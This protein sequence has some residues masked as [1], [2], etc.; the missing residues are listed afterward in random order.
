MNF[1]SG[2]QSAE[3]NILTLYDST[4][5]GNDYVSPE[6]DWDVTT[7]FKQL[8]SG[9]AWCVSVLFTFC[10]W[11][12]TCVSCAGSFLLPSALTFREQ[13]SAPRICWLSVNSGNSVVYPNPDPAYEL[14]GL[15]LQSLSLKYSF[16]FEKWTHQR[17]HL[18]ACNVKIV[19]EWK[20]LYWCQKTHMHAVL[21]LYPL[22]VWFRDVSFLQFKLPG[23]ISGCVTAIIIILF[24][25]WLRICCCKVQ[26]AQFVN[27][28]NFSGNFPLH[29][30]R[31]WS[32]SDTLWQQASQNVENESNK[33]E[34]IAILCI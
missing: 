15:F 11:R 2:R 19:K 7:A 16:Y 10:K 9:T 25:C 34:N 12:I 13:A 17:T 29:G 21:S 1:G 3:I 23:I 8:S 20:V 28:M 22:V 24:L 30:H 32:S 6:K 26:W 27:R 18:E 31:V 5:T 4:P 14:G 33:W